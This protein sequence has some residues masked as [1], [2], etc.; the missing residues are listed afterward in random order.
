MLEMG[1]YRLYLLMKWKLLCFIIPSCQLISGQIRYAI[2]EELNAGAF[3]GNIAEDLNLDVKQLSVRGFQIMP[4]PGKQYIDVNLDNGVLL[5]KEKM[6][7]EQLCEQ[8]LVCTL[9]LEAVIENPLNVYHFQVDILDVNDNAPRFPESQFRLEILEVAAPG[10]R[11]ALECAQDPDIGTNSV[12][13]YQLTEN[14]YFSLDVETLGGDGKVPVLVLERSLDREKESAHR[15]VLIANDGGVPRR[16]GS[17]EILIVVGDTNDNAPVFSQSIYRVSLWENAPKETLVIKLDASDLDADLNGQVVYSFGSHTSSRVREIF[18]LDSTTGEIRIKNNLDYEKNSVFEINVQAKDMGPYA[19]PVYCHVVVKILDVNDNAPVITLT[20]LFSPVSEDSLAGT[21]VALITST[22]KDSAENGDVDCEITQDLPF[23]LDSSVRNYYRLV[24]QHTLDREHV[25]AYNVTVVCTDA[26]VPPLTSNKTIPVEISDINDNP[27]QFTQ[28]VY[29]A[30]VMEN[31][32][33][34]ASIFTVTAFDQDS[35]RNA[36]VSYFILESQIQGMSVAAYV[37]INSHSG[38][39]FSQRSFDFENLKN[40]QLLVQARDSGSPPLSGN[41]SVDVIILDQNDNAPVIL[42]P[43]PEFGSTVSETISRLAEPGYLV[44]KVSAT[45]GDSGQNARLTY[46]ILQA[47]EVGLFTISPDTGEIWTIRSISKNDAVKQRLV[48]CVNDDGSPSLTATVTIILSL[49]GNDRQVLSERN[50]LSENP[51]FDFDTSFYLVIALG[52]TSS[53]FLVILIILAVKV[54]RSSSLGACGCLTVRNSLHGFQ[55]G[56]RTLQIPPNYVE[57]FGGDPLSQSFRYDSCS[58]SRSVK[59]D[60]R[61]SSSASTRKDFTPSGVLGN[62][63]TLQTAKSAQCRNTVN[64]V[65]LH[66]GSEK[67]TSWVSIGK[68]NAGAFVGNIAEDLNLNIKEFSARGFQIMPGP[69]KQYIDVNIDNGVLFVREKIDREQ[70][71]ERSL[72]CTLSVEAVIQNP[73]NVYH[74]HVDVLD[75][76]DNAPRFPDSRFILEISEVAAPG[77]HFALECA[78]DPDVGTNSVQSYQLL[79]NLYF[80]LDVEKGVGGEKLPVL[81]LERQLDREKETTHRVVLIAKDGGFPERSGT[82]EI[83]IIVEDANDNAPVFPQSV[84]R[85]VKCLGWIPNL[86][87]SELRIIWTTRKTVFLR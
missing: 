73:V 72:A 5:V 13:S 11:F 62:G 58:S 4:G 17:A 21:V 85:F 55:R 51:G 16:S 25:S 19:T 49:V 75:V 48:I 64:E 27:P 26:G 61:L 56:N 42:Q 80:S 87:K 67:S 20:S 70:L 43:L 10:T 12:Q 77:T 3:V 24:T 9:S 68:L 44:T 82:A 36:D 23:K 40:F 6:D 81:V 71:C 74:F 57:V 52:V 18:R 65:R 53:V 31:N 15:L 8:S 29:T 33:I 45:D 39:I 79:E 35:N 2:P 66:F 63:D 47:T 14:G 30:Y 1:L 46:Q 78:Q 38:V 37:S 69:S 34:G 60:F 32:A 86:A 54:H 83:L 50:S 59:R 22:D 41:A 28:P 7:R 76:N 84:Y